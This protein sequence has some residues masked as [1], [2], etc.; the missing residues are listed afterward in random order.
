M[1]CAIG[2]GVLLGSC[3]AAAR[4]VPTRRAA[5]VTAIRPSPETMRELAGR[6]RPMY[7]RHV[8]DPRLKAVLERVRAMTP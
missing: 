4:G 6:V 1:N 8:R 7:E 3:R 2:L 5:G